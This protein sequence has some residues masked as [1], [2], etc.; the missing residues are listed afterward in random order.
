MLSDEEHKEITRRVTKQILDRL[1]RSRLGVQG[2][3]GLDEG[4][5]LGLLM[6]WHVFD[7][8]FVDVSLDVQAGAST[9]D[10]LAELLQS[11]MPRN[12]WGYTPMD[13]FRCLLHGLGL[14]SESQ[15]LLAWYEEAGVLRRAYAARGNKRCIDWGIDVLLLDVC[16][17]PEFRRML[18]EILHG[19][20]IEVCELLPSVGQL[21]NYLWRVSAA[22]THYRRPI[23]RFHLSE[24]ATRTAVAA[25]LS[26]LMAV[27]GFSNETFVD[28]DL[29][30]D[31]LLTH[32]QKQSPQVSHGEIVRRMRKWLAFELR[33]SFGVK[34]NRLGEFF[35]GDLNAKLPDRL[36]TFRDVVDYVVVK[37]AKEAVSLA[38]GLR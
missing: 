23:Q 8:F 18:D 3:T 1:R 16:A 27:M 20:D 17:Q 14:N 28:E 21:V 11:R 25:D 4:S 7:T 33:W 35:W 36:V 29:M 37:R 2:E 9:V 24:P 19:I 6:V 38:S 34:R 5:N 31:E 22:A 26:R 30:V 32:A 13:L 15:Q 10:D 12:R